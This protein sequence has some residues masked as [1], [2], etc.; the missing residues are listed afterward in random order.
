[1]KEITNEL[2]F[3]AQKNGDTNYFFE[4]EG[5]FFGP[6]EFASTAVLGKIKEQSRAILRGLEKISTQ[7]SQVRLSANKIRF[8]P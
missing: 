6:Y 2:I 1:M 5:N 4:V 3:N 8:K 7:S